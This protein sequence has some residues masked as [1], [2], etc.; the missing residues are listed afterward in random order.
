MRRTLAALFGCLLTLV[1]SWA[2]AAEGPDARVP[3]EVPAPQVPA[4]Q[5]PAPQVPAAQVPA[6]QVPAAQVPAERFPAISGP[7]APDS[8]AT[9]GAAAIGSNLPDTGSPEQCD[10]QQVR[11]VSDRTHGKLSCDQNVLLD[12]PEVNDYLQQL[13]SRLA[14]QAEDPG[15]TFTYT[16]MRDPQINAFTTF[17]GFMSMSSAA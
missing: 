17:G 15:Q 6:P 1:A 7:S 9:T 14:S 4:P 16:A 5:V 13:G 12:D 2:P 8:F 10:V 3:V 11:R